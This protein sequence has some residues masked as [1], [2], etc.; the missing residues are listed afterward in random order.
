MAR[1]FVVVGHKASTT[2]DFKLD[3]IAGGAGRLDILVRCVNASF[4]LSHGIRRDAEA[5]LVLL[6]GE[7]APKTV[8]F[9]GEAI[10]YLNPDE[11]STSALVRNALMKPIPPGAEVQ[12]SPGVHVSRMSFGDVLDRLSGTGGFVYLKEDGED[13]RSA[14]L[15]P[16]PVFVLG[17]NR[18]LTEEEERLLLEKSPMA[19]SIG[20]KSLHADHC[21]IVAQNELDR[22]QGPEG[23]A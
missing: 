23:G 2:A 14:E 4:F 9:S 6:G 1:R 19:V 8:R 16:D 12:S 13:C 11:R 5:Y 22:R 18:D 7:D 10:R 3:D 21:I 17:D 15:P 20:P